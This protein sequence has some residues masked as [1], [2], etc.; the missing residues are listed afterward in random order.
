MG[1]REGQGGAQPARPP[2][3]ESWQGPVVAPTAL[4]TF[5]RDSDASVP[6]FLPHQGD[7]G[8]AA[9]FTDGTVTEP[10]LARRSVQTSPSTSE[11]AV[12]DKVTISRMVV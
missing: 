2:E 11:D 1:A 3:E 5:L 12:E 10:A 9:A 7:R 6:L 4:S 8:Q